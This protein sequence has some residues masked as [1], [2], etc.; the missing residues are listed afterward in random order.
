MGGGVQAASSFLAEFISL[1]DYLDSAEV[2]IFVSEEVNSSLVAMGFDLDAIKNYSVFNVYGL[3]AL[4]PDKAI[5]FLGFDL[6]LSLFGP[7]YLPGSIKNHLVGFAQAWILYPFNETSC[8]MG[9]FN[10]FRVRLKFEIQWLFFKFGAT[11]LIVELP[12]VRRRLIEF[13]GFPEDHIDVV[14]NCFSPIY[15]EESG[16]KSLNYIFD[17][18]PEVIRLGYLSRNY[19]HKNLDILLPVAKA[20]AALR[21]GCFE[22]YVTLNNEEW[23]QFSEEYRGVIFNVGPLCI[24]E[25][26]SFYNAMDG[27]IF[28]S[29]LECF[30]ATPLEAMVMQRPL[31]ASDRGF[32]RDVC[33]DHAIYVDPLD[34]VDIATKID[35]WFNMTTNQQRSHHLAR[36]HAHV[37]ALPSSKERAEGY[38]RIIQEQLARREGEN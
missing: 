34:P 7:I 23:A 19:F 1:R 25:C 13:R 14:E 29:L 21:A 36:A 31:F 5:R 38:V 3:D 15:L 26:P 4:R 33:G 17:K 16:W 2:H 35:Q 27:V 9:R 24:T 8:R 18:K 12:H 22:I 28:T 6:V 20:L 11:R 30:S 32:V 10:R 37:M